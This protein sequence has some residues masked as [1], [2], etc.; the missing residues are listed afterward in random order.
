MLFIHYLGT[1]YTQK[2]RHDW[3]SILMDTIYP[4]LPRKGRSKIP[5]NQICSD[6]LEIADGQ[7]IF[8]TPLQWSKSLSV[9]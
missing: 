4:I 7:K 8:Q 3:L 9:S 2:G 6:F 1:Q 5:Q